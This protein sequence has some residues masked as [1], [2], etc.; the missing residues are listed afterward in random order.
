MKI[1]RDVLLELR[2]SKKMSQYE[3]ARAAGVSVVTLNKLETSPDARP[4][5]ST[6]QKVANAL[7][8]NIAQLIL[9]D[10]SADEGMQ[11]IEKIYIEP[12]NCSRGIYGI[13]TETDRESICQY[14]GKSEQLPQRAAQH[15]KSIINKTSIPSLN[16]AVE[17][18]SINRI[19]IRLIERVDY[20]FDNYYRDAQRL[21]SRECFYIDFY[22]NKNQCLEQLPEGR[23]PNISAWEEMKTYVNQ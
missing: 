12:F 11:N 22:Q 20:V 14:I 18:S 1:N 2:T 7:G 3:L 19:A 6:I 23:R 5:S 9:S 17:D 8:V 13:F 4:F 10:P 21:S 16:N 15:K